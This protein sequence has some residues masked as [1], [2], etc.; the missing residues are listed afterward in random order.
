MGIVISQRATDHVVAH[1]IGH[2]LGLE[3]CYS[4]NDDVAPPVLV[5]SGNDSIG[6][7]FFSNAGRDWGPESGRGFYPAD[8]TIRSILSEFAMYGADIGDLLD[9]PS[10]AVY[11]LRKS[12]RSPLQVF[13]AK[14]GADY[15]KSDMTE[16]YSR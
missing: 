12:A 11:S 7:S 5:A 2:A 1:E 14:V 16:V 13:R 6:V 10:G 3:D 8:A 9:I 15:I 4:E